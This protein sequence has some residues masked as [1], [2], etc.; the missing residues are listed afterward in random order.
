MTTEYNYYII[1]TVGIFFDKTPLSARVNS[2][3]YFV[4]RDIFVYAFLLFLLIA[5]FLLMLLP[6]KKTSQGFKLTKDNDLVFS[7]VYGQE[8][9]V[10][11]E[12]LE[13][14]T[15]EKDGENYIVKISF[16][17]SY[18]VLYVNESQN[19]VKMQES[20]CPTKN[21]VHMREI[22][23]AG[24]IYCAPRK[25]KVSPLFEEFST[26]NVGGNG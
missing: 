17:E 10:E 4:K 19:S 21:C 6:G 26:P 12:Y 13:N 5:L 20:N 8:F 16:N 1:I 25:L 23:S 9:K 24:A 7:H 15:I 11:A 22:K 3:K 14:I 2:R 18:N